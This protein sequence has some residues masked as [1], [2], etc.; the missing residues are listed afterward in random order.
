M[1]RKNTL[2]MLQG[3]HTTLVKDK[4]PDEIRRQLVSGRQRAGLNRFYID[5]P[6]H[7]NKDS[8]LDAGAVVAL[9]AT[10]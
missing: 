7:G 5:M 9:I 8:I 6:D 3:G 10:C 1:E 2:I 4:T